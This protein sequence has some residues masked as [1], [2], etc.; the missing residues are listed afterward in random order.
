MKECRDALCNNPVDAVNFVGNGNHTVQSS[1]KSR[2]MSC[3]L[4]RCDK[5]PTN[6]STNAVLLL[7]LSVAKVWNSIALSRTYLR[8]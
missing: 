8:L 6:T 5:P 1:G 7:L 3:S 4:T 2:V